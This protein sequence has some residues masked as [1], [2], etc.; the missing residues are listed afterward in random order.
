MLIV[1]NDNKNR[2][3]LRLLKL[4]TIRLNFSDI[5][6]IKHFGLEFA[7]LFARWQLFVSGFNSLMSVHLVQCMLDNN[8]SLVAVIVLK[9][10]TQYNY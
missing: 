4:M 5:C 10:A 3:R 2:K 9:Q 6:R 8:G 7:S 1:L